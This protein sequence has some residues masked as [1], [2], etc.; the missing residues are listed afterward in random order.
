MKSRTA[1]VQ[2]YPRKPEKRSPCAKFADQPAC[3][4]KVVTAGSGQVIEAG[5]EAMKTDYIKLT[6]KG[7]EATGRYVPHAICSFIALRVLGWATWL[8]LALV[9]GG[10][11]LGLAVRVLGPLRL[12]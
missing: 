4:A 6:R 10:S 7:V 12:L 3:N 11:A 2:A 9:A 1:P 8:I 5:R